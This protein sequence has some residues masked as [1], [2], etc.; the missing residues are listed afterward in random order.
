M[1]ELTFELL[2]TSTVAEQKLAPPLVT[3]QPY[4]RYNGEYSN[5]NAIAIL[6]ITGSLDHL[7]VMFLLDLGAAVSV[8]YL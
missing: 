7:S 8:W 4:Q 5:F 1:L 3:H 2:W 6:K